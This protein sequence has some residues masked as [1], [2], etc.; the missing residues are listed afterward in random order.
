M[1]IRAETAADGQAISAVTAAAFEPVPH[2]DQR[3]AAIVD[4]LRDAGA[5]AISLVA[6]EHGRVVG[7][8]AFSP[9]AIGGKPGRWFGLGPV[10]VLPERQGVGIGAAL[11][12]EGLDRLRASGAEGCVLVGDPEYYRRFG[13]ASDPALRFGEAPSRYVQ[14]LGFSGAAPRGDVAYHPAFEAG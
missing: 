12:R 5:L 7:H 3:E 1:M 6:E 11:V 8:V 9:V 10:S 13:F 2:S 4:A 14:Y